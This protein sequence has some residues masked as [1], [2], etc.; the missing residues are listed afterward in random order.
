MLGSKLVGEN[1]AHIIVS[2]FGSVHNV[3][4]YVTKF[5]NTPKTREHAAYS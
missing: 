5:T 1:I 4:F 3:W 2:I